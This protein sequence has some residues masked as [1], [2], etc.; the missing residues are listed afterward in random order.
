MKVDDFSDASSLANL[1]IAILKSP[2]LNYNL[3]KRAF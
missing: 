1:N 3:Q 2:I